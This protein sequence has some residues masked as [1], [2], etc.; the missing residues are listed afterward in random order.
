MVL[1]LSSVASLTLAVSLSPLDQFSTIG[2]ARL[3]SNAPPL[4][5]FRN[6][7]SSQVID[8][9]LTFMLQKVVLAQLSSLWMKIRNVIA[10]MKFIKQCF[11]IVLF[12]TRLCQGKFWQ[13]IWEKVE[14]VY[15]MK[16]WQMTIFMGE[17]LTATTKT[18][19]D[20]IAKIGHLN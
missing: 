3:F 14:A 11:H 9:C 10:Q 18:H 12:I 5:K 17:T 8:G 15:E 16:Q 1:T 6:Y 19:V 7:K 4:F 20:G 2:K 13:A